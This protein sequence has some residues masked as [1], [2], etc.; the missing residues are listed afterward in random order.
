MTIYDYIPIEHTGMS[1]WTLFVFGIA[2]IA[3]MVSIK[4]FDNWKIAHDEYMAEQTHRIDE[5]ERRLSEASTD[6]AVMKADLSYIKQ[7]L[8]E[9]KKPLQNMTELTARLFENVLDRK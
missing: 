4:L 8:D 1:E 6:K 2:G 5:H 9:I 3:T 7:S